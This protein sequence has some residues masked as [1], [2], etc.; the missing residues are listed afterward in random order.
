MRE[1][2]G[3]SVVNEVAGAREDGGGERWSTRLK[4]IKD[5]MEREE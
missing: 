1:G 4:S 3:S 2:I 5:S